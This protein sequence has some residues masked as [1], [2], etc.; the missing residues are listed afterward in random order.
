METIK[1]QKGDY[2]IHCGDE[3]KQIHI[4]I[5]GSMRMQSANDRFLVPNGSIIGLLE[6]SG[7]AYNC[8]YYAEEDSIIVAYPFQSIDDFKQIFEE[9]QEYAFAFFHS[10][11]V[12]CMQLI[13]RYLMLVSWLRKHGKTP[14]EDIEVW[15][16]LYYKSLQQKD[17][18][19]LSE[20]YGKDNNLC[21]GEI[22]RASEFMSRVIEGI[23]EMLDNAECSLEEVFGEVSVENAQADTNADEENGK[24]SEVQEQTEDTEDEE[25]GVDCL[26]TI[27][28]YAGQNE[29]AIELIREKITEFRNLPEIYSTDDDVRRL[30]RELTAIFIQIYEKVFFRAA[31]E[32]E[33]LDE[34]IQMFLNFG[35]MDVKLAGAE[36]ADALYGLTEHLQLCNSNHV[37]TIYE[38]LLAVYEGRKEPSRN[39]FDMDYN[40]YLRD[41]MKSGNFRK[42]ELAALSD[43]LE[44]KVKF[45][46]RNMF[47]STNRATYGRYATYCPILRKEDLTTSV[48]MLLTTVAKIDEALK[49]VTDIDYSCFY[50]SMYVADPAHNLPKQE[51]K[52]ELFPDVILMPNCGC[53]AMMW[54]EAA[55]ARGEFPA[56]FMLPIFN[57]GS[58]EDMILECCGRFRWEM[59]RRI[60]G[61]RWNDIREN[62]LTAEYCDYLQFYRKNHSLTAEAREKIKGS[63]VKA[64]N[65]FREVFVADYV[66]WIKYESQG[67]V[68]LNKVARDIVFRYCPFSKNIRNKLKESPMYRDMI[69][70]FEIL[71]DR[72]VKKVQN[73]F[74]KYEKSGGELLPEMDEYLSYF[75]L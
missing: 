28:Q 22:L 53:K 73:A 48:T 37:Y 68:R 7:M 25:Q 36:N 74:A 46:I 6:C 12:E 55:G 64:K 61:M 4:V 39:E 57:T 32:G 35:F 59:C 27:L 20:M 40:Q 29:K 33:P 54:Q 67:S 38:W 16:V 56:R 19:L 13:E 65:N 26:Q 60:Q 51:V 41:Q 10:A 11:I 14:T 47:Q 66:A 23:N 15:E 8:D 21:I 2:L 58:V 24:E 71:N 34:I 49:H 9:N 18:N 31:E 44:E 17:A 52:Y 63:I 42:E 5:K 62:S 70:K 1:L 43:D 50:R 75:E 69:G 3:M 45:E 72:E 30:R